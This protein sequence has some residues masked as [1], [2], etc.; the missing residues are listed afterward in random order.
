M[1]VPPTGCPSLP[2][3]PSL[4]CALASASI[5]AAYDRGWLTRPVSS[6]IPPGGPSPERLSR[7][8]AAVLVPFEALIARATRRGRHPKAQDD[9]DAQLAAT[10]AL[11]DV[12]TETL[13]DT[14]IRPRTTQ[15]RLVQTASRLR[16]E[17]GI[18]HK[19]F[20][21][22]L[23]VPLRTLRFWATRPKAPPPPPTPPPPDAPG[24]RPRNDGRFALE[25]CPPGLQAVGDTTTL[26]VFGASGHSCNFASG[27]LLNDPPLTLV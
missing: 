25:L 19:A 13:R 23:G 15:D 7:L 24:P 9:R 2:S 22:A 20:A 3:K 18:T 10:R 12:A 26:E 14:K 6:L 27:M 21:Q 17:H 11:L 5:V 4:L 16:H 1:P 8:K